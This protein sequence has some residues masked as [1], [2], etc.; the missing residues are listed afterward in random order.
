MNWYIAV[1]KKYAVFEGRARR[2]EFWMYMLF[3]YIFYV[4]LGMLAAMAD[5]L[6]ILF[7][8]YFLATFL[9]GLG[10]SIRRLH[11]TNRSGWWV[12]ISFIPF[13]GAIILLVF[14]VQEGQADENAYGPNPKTDAPSA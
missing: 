9:P 7:G 5:S 1:L 6:A 3:N 13:I 8:I 10:V 2:K 14:F 12:L 11:D 4:V